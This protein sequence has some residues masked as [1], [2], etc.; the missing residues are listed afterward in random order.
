M[1]APNSFKQRDTGKADAL[2][3]GGGRAGRLALLRLGAK[4]SALVEPNPSQE[5]LAWGGEIIRQDGAA[6]VAQ[7]LEGEQPPRWVVPCL[8]RHLLLEWLCLSLAGQRPRL[9]SLPETAL[10]QAAQRM[11][12][13]QGAWYLSLTDTLCPDDCAE[14][15]RLCPKTGQ[16]RGLSLQRRLAGIKLPGFQVAVLRSYQL[17]PGVGGLLSSQMLKLRQRMSQL[18]GSWVLG[19]SCRC[20][21]VAQA[22]ELDPPGGGGGRA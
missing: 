22:L 17:A 5:V 6:A 14:P 9:L 4:V 19:T 1:P 8:P 18:G 7:A 2:V 21:G 15:A 3:V 13:A 10:P 12:G 11:A 16:E 20:H